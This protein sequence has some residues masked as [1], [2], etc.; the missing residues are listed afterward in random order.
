VTVGIKGIERWLRWG[1]NRVRR[2]I[3]SRSRPWR[4]KKLHY[5]EDKLMQ[6]AGNQ[7]IDLIKNEEADF[8]SDETSRGGEEGV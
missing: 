7:L 4:R 6:I 2:D 1:R 5:I 3:P 8:R